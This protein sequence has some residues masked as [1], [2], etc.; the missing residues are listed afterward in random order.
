MLGIWLVPQSGH[1]LQNM[2]VDN[3]GEFGLNVSVNSKVEVAE[4]PYIDLLDR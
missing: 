3:Q 4:M 2:S 1:T